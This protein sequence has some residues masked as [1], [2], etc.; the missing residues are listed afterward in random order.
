MPRT[1]VIL[2][3]YAGRG[4]AAQAFPK[5]EAALRATGLELEVVRTTGPLHAVELAREAAAEGFTGVVA[6]G[7]DGILNEIVNGL[8]QAAH[9][10]ETLPVGIIPLGRGND[11]IKSLPPAL[12]PGEHRDD[13]SQAIPRLLSGHTIALDVGKLTADVPLI[14]QPHPRYF[15]NG[16][17][18]GFGARVAKAV[19]KIPFSGMPAYLLGILQVLADYDLP[20]IKLT[21]DDHEVIELDTTLTAVTNGRCFGSS[22]WLTPMAELNDG[23]LEVLMADAL[24]R[25]GILQLIPLLMKGE[26]LDHPAVHFR[27][28]R[29]VV[30][31]SA[32]PLIVEADGE[33]PFLAARRL[34]VEILP[35]RLRVM[36]EAPA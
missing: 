22:F 7:G 35:A 1:L 26:H 9:D 12:T 20:H 11:T 27:R 32:K 36:V 8:M 2:N 23:Y 5:V 10:G 34:Q 25:L 4:A 15:I 18:V 24:G 3:P 29:K 13:W 28:A 19:G 6:V 21:L 31:E 17:D 14:S 30:I 16:M 33:L